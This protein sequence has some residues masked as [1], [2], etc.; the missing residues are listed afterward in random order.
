MK[1]D[2]CGHEYGPPVGSV[3]TGF[4]ILDGKNIC[5][6]CCGELDLESMKTLD[7]TVLYLKEKDGKWLA[8]N[9]PGT[10]ELPARVVKMPKRRIFGHIVQLHNAWVTGPDGYVWFGFCNLEN[11]DCIRLRK[12]GKRG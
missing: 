12:T 3:G 1:C 2:R 8:T 4:G 7:R 6:P 5:Y 11:G 9:W 10:L